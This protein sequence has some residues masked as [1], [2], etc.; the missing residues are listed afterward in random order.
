MQFRST[1]SAKAGDE[2][3]EAEPS[4]LRT[5]EAESSTLRAFGL[6]E[7]IANAEQPPSLDDLTRA[8]GLPKP[9]VYRILGLLA[10]GDLV[11][12]EPFEKRYVVGPRVSAL[13]LAVQVRSPLRGERHAILERLVGEIGETCNFTM[14]D[15]SEVLYVDRVET[16]A[17]VRLHVKAGSRVPLH[18]TAS[19]KLFLAYLPPAQV[20]SLLGPRSLKRYTERTIVDPGALERE[21]RKVRSS[22]IGTDIGEYLE[23]SVCLAVPVSD[24][25][26][27]V[28][29]AI[30]VHGPAPRMTLKKGID[31]LPALKRAAAAIS[32]TIARSGGAAAQKSPSK[33]AVGATS[34]GA[35]DVRA[36]HHHRGD[37]RRAA[38]EEGQSRRP[39]DAFRAD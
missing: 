28:C 25:Q 13:S 39:G 30:A 31:F 24:P 36:R 6:L 32:T 10:R 4:T 16:P 26:G 1:K 23:G 19:G 37:H 35:T 12:R 27:R 29:A 7:F 34:R 5:P 33:V 3:P 15:G 8:S 38:E 17:S 20:R 18:C 21:L 11:Q 14:L 9:T 22:G 2:A